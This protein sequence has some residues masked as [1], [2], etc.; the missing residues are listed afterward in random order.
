MKKIPSITG[1]KGILVAFSLLPIGAI[2][3]LIF[4]SLI[5][6]IPATLNFENSE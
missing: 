6:L 3:E 1:D 4:F 2:L 5:I